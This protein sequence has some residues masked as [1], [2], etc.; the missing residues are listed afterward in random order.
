MFSQHI[1]LAHKRFVL[2]KVNARHSQHIPE[3]HYHKAYVIKQRFFKQRVH[4]ISAAKSEQTRQYI[5]R[6]RVLPFKQVN[7]NMLSEFQSPYREYQ[8]SDNTR[9]YQSRQISVMYIAVMVTKIKGA[10]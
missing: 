4:Q 2:I 6:T 5:L 8:K 9:R 1:M 3:P 10:V 7:H